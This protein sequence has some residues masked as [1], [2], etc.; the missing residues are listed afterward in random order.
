LLALDDWYGVL[1]TVL[2]I[3]FGGRCREAALI[4]VLEEVV[5]VYVASAYYCCY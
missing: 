2:G 3:L 1:G 5:E 4:C